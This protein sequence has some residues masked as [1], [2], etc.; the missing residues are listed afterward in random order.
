MLSPSDY[1]DD[2]GI[3]FKSWEAY[4]ACMEVR[5]I[6]ERLNWR[7]AENLAMEKADECKRLQKRID[8]LQT[9]SFWKFLSCWFTHLFT[10][11]P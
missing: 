6:H 4:A 9:I 5:L 2:E 3:P 10:K 1:R 11:K 7:K 8:G